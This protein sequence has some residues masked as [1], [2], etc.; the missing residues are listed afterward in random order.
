MWLVAYTEAVTINL[1]KQGLTSVPRNELADNAEVV[2]LSGNDIGSIEDHDFA[3]M[4]SL[5]QLWLNSNKIAHISKLAFV[6]SSNVLEID[7]QN[8]LLTSI[9][10]LALMGLQLEKIILDNNPIFAIQ[11]DDLLGF[12]T[13]RYISARDTLL[14]S[15]PNFTH[16]ASSLRAIILNRNNLGDIDGQLLAI[17]TILK[18]IRIGKCKLT[19]IPDLSGFPSNNQI[20]EL[21]LNNEELGPTLRATAFENLPKVNKINLAESNLVEFPDFG[22][23]KDTLQIIGLTRNQISVVT[24][25]QLEGMLKLARLSLDHNLLTSFPDVRSL[26][27]LVQLDLRENKLICDA[28][29]WWIG[30]HLVTGHNPNIHVEDPCEGMIEQQQSAV[31]SRVTGGSPPGDQLSVCVCECMVDHACVAVSVQSDHCV[32]VQQLPPFLASQQWWI[33]SMN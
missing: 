31:F 18:I 30:E 33:K 26:A 7:I 23:A 10:Q 25:T 6:N 22:S 11:A 24:S 13:L 16:I 29:I 3:N 21:Y 14:T 9:R 27:S 12:P 5:Q 17:P 8:N 15:F 28:G 2:R 20:E 1:S 32:L 19:R 4:P